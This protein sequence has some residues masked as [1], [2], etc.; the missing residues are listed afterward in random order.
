MT[1]RIDDDE[2][3]DDDD[4]KVEVMTADRSMPCDIRS[5][6]QCMHSCTCTQLMHRC[7]NFLFDLKFLLL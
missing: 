7:E 3:E 4:D 1:R 2:D 6:D 5:R